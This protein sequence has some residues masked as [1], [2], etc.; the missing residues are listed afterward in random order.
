MLIPVTAVF[1]VE[2]VSP[3]SEVAVASLSG[4]F[5]VLSE[6]KV[7]TI[8]GTAYELSMPTVTCSLE[9]LAYVGRTV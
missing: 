9:S 6:L 7:L 1:L 5:D 4:L 2:R 8:P 3:S